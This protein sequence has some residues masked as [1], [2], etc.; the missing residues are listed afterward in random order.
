MS[1]IPQPAAAPDPRTFWVA[2]GALTF[3]S[4]LWGSMVPLTAVALQGYD[5]FLLS[6]TRYTIGTAVLFAILLMSRR[7]MPRLRHL[8]WGRVIACGIAAGAFVTL[9]TVSLLLSDPI[10]ISA[11][12]AVAPLIAVLMDRME[13]HSR[14]SRPIVIGI[15]GAVGG[16]ILVAL[17]QGGEMRLRGGELLVF[18]GIAV[19]TWYSMKTQRWL[20]PLGLNQLQISALTL[21]CGSAMLWIVWA[22]VLWIGIVE[23]PTALPPVDTTAAMLCLAFGPTATAICLWNYGNAKVGVTVATLM[24]N[25]SPVFS[26]VIAIAFGYYPT[27][28]QIIGG[29]IVLAGVVWMQVA[30][31]RQSSRH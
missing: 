30:L 19:W 4:F 23:M 9:A 6:P 25:T 12:F 17:G 8:P 5:A 14:I 2:T 21:A 1:D 31:T 7:R 16:G 27:L 11:A 20:A 13:T 3:T 15:V 18:L 10:S 29:A 28:L 26:V 24:I 22:V